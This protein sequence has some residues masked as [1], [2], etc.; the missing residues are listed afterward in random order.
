MPGQPESIAPPLDTATPATTAAAANNEEPVE[1]GTYLDGQSVL[2]RYAPADGAWFRLLPR[3]A[4]RVGDRLLALPAFNPQITLASGLHLKLSG[5]TQVTLETMQ[6]GAIGAG[7]SVPVL[8]VAYGQLVIVNTANGDNNLR[9]KLGSTAAQVRLAQSSTVALEVTRGY[10][11]GRDPRQSASPM[12][13]HVFVPN[14]SITWDDGAG[15]QAIKAPSR[16]TITAGVASASTAEATFPEWIDQEQA[17]QR[18][19]Q[20]YG[21]PV[22]E[23]TLVA[24]RPVEDQLLELYQGSRR[25]EVKSLVARS[26]VYVGLFVPF[27]EALRDSEQRATWK[28]HIE[29]LRSA[30]ALGPES[31]NKIWETLV[32]QRGEPAARD[33]FEMLCGYSPEQVGKTPQQISAG[34]VPRLVDWLENDS[35]DYRVLA[36]QN[37]AE[38]TGKRLLA[39][40]AGTPAERAKGVRQWRERLR[41]GEVVPTAG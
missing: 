20:L 2:L 38:I 33:L 29:T 28:M 32:E 4:L 6:G 17:E 26:S 36:V 18:S 30:M 19:E 35:L 9:L 3:T 10:V 16:W 12:V 40:P 41:S 14:G 7:R 22:V 37:L 21:A 15:E 11:P 39:N 1:L 27:I 24:T 5:G 23:Q 34:A 31:A 25:R 13:V 8:D